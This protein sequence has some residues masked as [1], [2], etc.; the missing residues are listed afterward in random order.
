MTR[1]PSN[2]ALAPPRARRL[3]RRR[4]GPLGALGC[5]ATWIAV[6]ASG[7]GGPAPA[8]PAPSASARSSPA[9][10][11]EPTLDGLLV[12]GRG[13]LLVT[14]ATGSLV[15]FEPPSTRAVAVTASAGVVVTIDESGDAALFDTVASGRDWKALGLPA[16]AGSPVRLAA[17]GPRGRELAIVAGEAQGA[18]FDLVVLPLDGGPSHRI[19]VARGLNGAPSWLGP[20]TVAIDVIRAD[21]GSGIAT[22]EV[23]TGVVTDR[24]GPATIVASTPDGI[25]VAIDDPLTGDVLVG[26]PAAW[27]ANAVGAMTRIHGPPASGAER[28]AISADGL[29]LAVVRRIDAG[30]TIEILTRGAVEWRSVRRLAMPGDGPISV[31]WIE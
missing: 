27:R 13:P 18:S 24:P 20:T 14:D 1:H 11:A 5:A 16:A 29:R 22:I 3:G 6:V 4:A 7:C 26:D 19:S 10:A 21:G 12:A 31:A 2:T 23:S 28:L 8:T 30:S 9:P 25:L 15:R 17:V